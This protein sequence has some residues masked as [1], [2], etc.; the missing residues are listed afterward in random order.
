MPTM[1]AICVWRPSALTWGERWYDKQVKRAARRLAGRCRAAQHM[2]VGVGVRRRGA[3]VAMAMTRGRALPQTP[4]AAAAPADDA[5]RGT[6]L[7]GEWDGGGYTLCRC[8]DRGVSILQQLI[9]NDR[10]TRDKRRRVLPVRI[11]GFCL[12]YRNVVLY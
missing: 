4:I 12:K 8:F 7:W 9:G 5:R 3:A 11:Y 2:G 6:A 1:P 10:A